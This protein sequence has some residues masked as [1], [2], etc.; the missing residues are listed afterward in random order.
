MTDEKDVAAGEKATDSSTDIGWGLVPVLGP[1][2]CFELLE[3]LEG[4]EIFLLG[5]LTFMYTHG[6]SW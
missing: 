1:E 2:Y 5:A 4:S 3:N 6:S